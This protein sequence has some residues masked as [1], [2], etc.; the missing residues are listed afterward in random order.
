MPSWPASLLA[1]ASKL[2]DTKIPGRHQIDRV[3]RLQGIERHVGHTAVDDAR[4]DRDLGAS[5]KLCVA[6][7]I[8]GEP[9]RYRA[10]SIADSLL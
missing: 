9:N 1:P 7:A 6:A 2:R 10:A 3:V 4:I 5:S 8:A